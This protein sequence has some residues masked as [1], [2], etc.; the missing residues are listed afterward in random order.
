MKPK[1]QGK[2]PEGCGKK[3]EDFTCGEDNQENAGNPIIC[4]ECSKEKNHSP[5]MATPPKRSKDTPSELSS[6]EESATAGPEGTQTQQECPYTGNKGYVEEEDCHCFCCGTHRGKKPRKTDTDTYTKQNSIPKNQYECKRHGNAC[7]SYVVGIVKDLNSGRREPTE[8]DLKLVKLKNHSPQ[9]DK[10]TP[11]G[12]HSKGGIKHKE[13]NFNLSKLYFNWNKGDV[14][15]KDN[16][17]FLF[18][19][20]K[21]FIIKDT[22]LINDF[23]NGYLTFEELCRERQKLAGDDLI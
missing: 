8:E 15:P 5:G 2:K 18:E 11:S 9:V 6:T 3:F 22:Q 19:D 4:S 10:D 21:K 23:K 12:N 17:Y 14:I 20:V 7:E 1:N 16:I 13:G